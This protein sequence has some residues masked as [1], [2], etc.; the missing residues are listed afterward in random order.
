[1]AGTLH[2]DDMKAAIAN[3]CSNF[4]FSK[5][6][7]L[8]AVFALL[9]LFFAWEMSRLAPDSSLERMVPLKHEYIR[10][11]FKHKDELSLGNDIRIAVVARQGDIFNRA[12]METLRQISDEMFLMKGIDKPNFK[13]LWTPNVRW[14]EVTENGFEGSEVIPPDFNGSA[15]SIEQLRANVLRSGQVGR[16]V[17]DDFRSTV[18][19][20]PLMESE[21]LDYQA[22]SRSL[23]TIRAKYAA[24]GVDIHIV[25]FAK[26]VGDLISGVQKIAIFFLG[27]ILITFALLFIYSRCLKSSSVVVLCSLIAVIWQL[28]MLRVIGFGLDPY[29]VLVPFLVFAIAVSHSVQLINAVGTHIVDEHTPYDASCYAFTSLFVAG[30]LGLACEAIGFMTLLF[31]DIGVIRNLAIASS[32]GVGFVILTNFVLL[33]IIMSYAGVTH[34]SVKYRIRRLRAQRAGLWEMVA[35][36]TDKFSI[37]VIVVSATLLLVS[38][39]GATQVRIGDLDQGA[40]ELW[41]DS[42]YNRDV[43]FLTSHYSISADVLVVMVETPSQMCSSYATL[44]AVDRFQWQMENTQGVQSVVSLVNGVKQVVMSFNEGNPKWM[45]LAN[46]DAVLNEAASKLPRELSN[47]DCSLIPVFVFLA[48]HKAETLTRVTAEVETF[49]RTNNKGDELKFVLASG[50]AGIEAATNQEIAKVKTPMLLFVYGVVIAL[51]AVVF[52]S[53]RA[54]VCIIAPLVLTSFLCEALMAVMG[55]GIKVATLPVIALGV[56]IGVDYG[57]YIYNRLEELMRAGQPLHQA[58]LETLKTTGT[59]VSFTGFTLAIGVFTW[60]FS[61]IKFQ[62]DMG[63]LLT[64]M[65]LWNMLGALVLLP[66]LAHFLLKPKAGD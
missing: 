16:L 29:S 8:L 2:G 26:K 7:P 25:G 6:K 9:T 55:I 49:A 10:N 20:V 21:K 39:Y 60:V 32:I 5:R 30:V 12:Y 61:P 52:R 19:Y 42:T 37:P 43:A 14:M 40:P 22:F 56:G 50:N 11:L 64:F 57:I 23:E 3:T 45:A 4:I 54:L 63:I 46:D 34:A 41:P 24:Q 58:Y 17:A 59:A 1:M 53:W 27:A 35:N 15:V 28:G 18:V 13:S 36:A 65:F 51:C 31:I 47:I 62:A 44:E 48:D 66:A 33:P 38:I